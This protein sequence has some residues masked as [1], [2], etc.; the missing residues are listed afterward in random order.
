MRSELMVSHAF[1][2]AIPA[3]RKEV[4]TSY[5]FKLPNEWRISA[6]IRFKDMLIY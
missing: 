5:R 3:D 2:P 6:L 4:R 1:R